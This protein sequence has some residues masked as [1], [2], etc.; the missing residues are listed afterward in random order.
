MPNHLHLL[1]DVWDEPLAKLIG[2]WK[3]VIAHEA[4]KFLKRSGEFWEREHLDTVIKD[5]SHRQTA[6]KYIEANPVKAG[7]VQEAKEWSWSSA[8][9]RDEYGRLPP[10]APPP[11][12]AVNGRM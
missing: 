12:V 3:G 4:N 9:W 11:S 6:V 1:V 5:D 8:R 7:L 10:G 2:G